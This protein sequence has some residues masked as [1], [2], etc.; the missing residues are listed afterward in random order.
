MA[1]SAS[2]ETST[3]R[4]PREPGWSLAAQAWR[5]RPLTLAL[6][7][8]VAGTAVTL[9]LGWST[10]LPAYLVLCAA[11]VT[12]AA[13]DARTLRLPDAVLLPS[14]VVVLALLGVTALVDGT[15]S[16]FLRALLVAATGF[17]L[18]LVLA[19]INPSGLGLGDVKLAAVLGL[20][21]GHVGWATAFVGLLAA[22]VLMALVG[23]VLL[24]RRRVTRSSAVPFGP[25]MLL[26]TLVAL[27]ATPL[28]GTGMH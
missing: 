22:F 20:A 27:L 4:E 16:A 24:A 26:G 18:F 3:L 10:A 2:A 8:V 11:G 14:G 25:F 13:I 1:V 12:L 6:A 7:V 19:L 23:V 21:L 28:A 5:R 17:G 9:R 15:G